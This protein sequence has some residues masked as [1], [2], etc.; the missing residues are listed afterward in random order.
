MALAG[1]MGASAGLTAVGFAASVLGGNL[2]Y[3]LLIAT[4]F[5]VVMLLGICKLRDKNCEKKA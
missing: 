4:V 3:E 5:A 1:D 2:K